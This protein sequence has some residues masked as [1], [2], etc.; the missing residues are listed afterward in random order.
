MRSTTGWLATIA[1]VAFACGGCSSQDEGPTYAELLTIYNAE[2]ETLERLQR[3]RAA[4]VAE[5]EATLRPSTEEAVRALLGDARD[6][7]AAAREGDELNSADP[8]EQLDAIIG[9]AEQAEAQVG[10]LLDAVAQQ[11]GGTPADREA[12]EALYSDEFKARLAELDAEIEQQRERVAKAR[13]A[14]D[15]AAPE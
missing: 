4:M 2:A 14:R 1:I 12:I 7:T 10:A 8:N 3:Q 15:A 11:G 6:A 13:A 5:Y 9:N